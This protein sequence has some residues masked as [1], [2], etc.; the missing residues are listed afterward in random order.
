M[1]KTLVVLTIGMLAVLLLATP[2]LA[3]GGG[4]SKSPSFN[5][6]G[7]I[8]D[9]DCDSYTMLVDQ[10]WPGD[11]TATITLNDYTLYRECTGSRGEGDEIQCNILAA[12]DLVRIVGD[13]DGTLVATRVIL[14]PPEE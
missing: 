5:L 14:Y 11:G 10:L 13:R 3:A 12:G 1:R 4:G 7:N 2:G 9:V 8:Q 6:Y